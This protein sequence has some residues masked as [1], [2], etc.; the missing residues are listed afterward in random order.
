MNPIGLVITAIAGAAYLIYRYWEP[1][2]GFFSW[3]MA[4]S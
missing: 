2:K 3:P 4:G 1:I